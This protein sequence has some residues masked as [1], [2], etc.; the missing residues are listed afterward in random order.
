[1]GFVY[2]LV[3][4]AA[5]TFI[6]AFY[7]SKSETLV[8]RIGEIIYNKQNNFIFIMDKVLLGL[9]YRYNNTQRKEMWHIFLLCDIM[10]LV[11]TDCF[12]RIKKQYPE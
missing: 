11:N 12:R 1:M 2:N 9:L 8:H 10:I 7:I 6:Y 3:Y 4:T 5:V